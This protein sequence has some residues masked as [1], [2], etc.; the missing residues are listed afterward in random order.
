MLQI[1][2]FISFHRWQ[3][4]A[5]EILKWNDYCV[6]LFWEIL[7]LAIYY[8]NPELV[9]N[10]RREDISIDVECVSIFLILH[11]V[12]NNSNHRHNTM[13]AAAAA[14]FDSIW[15]LNQEGEVYPSSPV[16]SPVSSPVRES[17]RAHRIQSPGNSPMSPRS[18][19]SSPQPS[20]PKRANSTART[21]R[22]STHYLHSVQQK[23]PLILKALCALPDPNADENG[24]FGE[25]SIELSPNCQINRRV[26]DFLG[27]IMCGGH[28]RDNAV[29]RTFDSNYDLYLTNNS[30]RFLLL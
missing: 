12:D 13:T 22:G 6:H 21:P 29:S 28:S 9:E 11:I 10:S 5:K 17:N 8:L 24:G 19:R 1:Y 16:A 18:P 30:K 25:S 23:I 2:F 20:S 27:L 4:L 3:T 15:P 7:I 14:S 26:V